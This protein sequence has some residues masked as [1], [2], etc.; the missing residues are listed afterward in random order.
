MHNI[1]IY[2]FPYFIL[3]LGCI[4]NEKISYPS[5]DYD[6][7]LRRPICKL[8]SNNS[9]PSIDKINDHID[10]CQ[11]KHMNL[12]ILTSTNIKNIQIYRYKNRINCTCNE[13]KLNYFYQN[14]Y[15]IPQSL[16]KDYNQHNFMKTLQQQL[17]RMTS[18][19]TTNTAGSLAVPANATYVDMNETKDLTF[20]YSNMKF[21]QFFC[22]D[23]K[24]YTSC[25]YL[26]N[27]CVL[28]MYVGVNNNVDKNS[29]CYT[30]YITQT[31]DLATRNY[32]FNQ[33]NLLP[34]NVNQQ[35]D[36]SETMG[37][38]DNDKIKPFLYYKKGGKFVNELFD[39]AIDFSYALDENDVVST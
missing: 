1:N 11:V 36:N 9:K 18:T 33:N 7:I 12:T 14:E 21:L 32:L 39:K 38:E 31:I 26:A 28:E 34:N 30:F 27:L 3:G 5:I 17:N 24:N 4:C 29:P 15:C 16:L 37:L 35:N 13:Y 23:I 25:N 20:I 2:L 19:S 10:Q 6:N 8:K 22:Q